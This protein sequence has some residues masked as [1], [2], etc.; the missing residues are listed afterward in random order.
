MGRVA[1]GGLS[2]GRGVRSIRE[3]KR[4]VRFIVP[5]VISHRG[6]SISRRNAGELLV[7]S[8]RQAA[9]VDVE[10]ES[11]RV[12]ASVAGGRVTRARTGDTVSV[13]VVKG[14]GDASS[15]SLLVYRLNL[16]NF[17]LVDA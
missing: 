14:D 7:L 11:S 17:E 13:C 3:M 1:P 2:H 8:Y 12:V 16:G 6:E 15:D 4:V 5:G 9:A 10:S